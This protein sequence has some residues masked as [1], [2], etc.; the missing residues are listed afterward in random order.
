MFFIPTQ[1][2]HPRLIRLENKVCL[3]N[4][5][6]VLMGCSWVAVTVKSDMSTE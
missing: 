2:F 5:R 6:V 1:H 3:A 4:C